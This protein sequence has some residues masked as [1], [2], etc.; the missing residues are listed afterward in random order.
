MLKDIYGNDLP[1]PSDVDQMFQA[2]FLRPGCGQRSAEYKAGFKRGLM[3]QVDK[4][5]LKP[6][7]E[8]DLRCL[9]P[10]GTCQFDAWFAGSDDGD[11]YQIFCAD[12]FA[13]LALR[14]S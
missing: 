6:G 14:G 4:T 7:F 5:Y 9:F 11:R 12:R 3:I 13:D 10:Q 1:D 2:R 8:R